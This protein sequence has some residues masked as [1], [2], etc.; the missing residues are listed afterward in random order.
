MGYPNSGSRNYFNDNVRDAMEMAKTL[1]RLLGG[2][3]EALPHLDTLEKVL[4]SV[5]PDTLERVLA[6]MIRRLIRMKALDDWRVGGRF[7]LAIDGTGLYSF[8]QAKSV[9]V[10]PE[11]SGCTRPRSKPPQTISPLSQAHY[12][13][14]W[15]SVFPQP[16]C[17]RPLSH[18]PSAQA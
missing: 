5:Q 9:S 7:L 4:R 12:P 3:W 13:S 6:Q 17:R 11:H 10:P 2:E 14:A 15:R 16:P 18:P 8:R 1:A